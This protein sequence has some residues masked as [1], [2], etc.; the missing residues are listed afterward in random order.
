MSG[1]VRVH[2]SRPP[3]RD[4]VEVFV[5]RYLDD[6]VDVGGGYIGHRRQCLTPEGEWIDIPDYEVMPPAVT[7]LGCDRYPFRDGSKVDAVAQ[8]LTA[9]VQALLD[10]A[11][12]S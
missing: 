1:G 9:A 8:S 11:S 2:V 5:F 4:V 6:W 3:D 12:G 10:G 7:A